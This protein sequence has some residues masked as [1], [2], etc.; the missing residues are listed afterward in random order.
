MLLITSCHRERTP[1]LCFH[2]RLPRWSGCLRADMQDL[3]CL[4]MGRTWGRV[5]ALHQLRLGFWVHGEDLA[6]RIIEAHTGKGTGKLAY[7]PKEAYVH[8][9]PCRHASCISSVP[10][11]RCLT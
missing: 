1:G 2:P 5:V 11:E 7:Y 4:F 9:Q 8:R 6:L 3:L 10:W